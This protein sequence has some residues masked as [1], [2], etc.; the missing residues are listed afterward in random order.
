MYA[1]IPFAFLSPVAPFI[2][3][4]GLAAGDSVHGAKGSADAQKALEQALKDPEMH[5]QFPE[6]IRQ[7][8]QARLDNA[9]LIAA[10]DEGAL[11]DQEI[12]AMLEVSDLTIS[13]IL[14]RCAVEMS[15]ANIRACCDV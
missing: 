8:A 14:T 4:Y 5:R 11:A 1:A 2:A 15:L 12:D 9:V 7:T 3:Y 6:Q 13:L 10:P